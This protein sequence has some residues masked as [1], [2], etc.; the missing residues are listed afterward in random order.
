MVYVATSNFLVYNSDK[1]QKENI[2]SSLAIW[3]LSLI[4]QKKYGMKNIN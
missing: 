2:R 3:N 1:E 4:S